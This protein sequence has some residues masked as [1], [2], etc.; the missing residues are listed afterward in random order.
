MKERLIDHA[1]YIREVFPVVLK[2]ENDTLKTYWT[3]QQD[4]V[5]LDVD[6]LTQQWCKD[7]FHRQRSLVCKQSRLKSSQ[8]LNLG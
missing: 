6:H 5:I 8:L 7:N 4:G 2:Y 1:Q 3:F